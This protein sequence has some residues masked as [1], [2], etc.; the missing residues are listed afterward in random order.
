MPVF[1]ISLPDLSEQ[2]KTQTD[3]TLSDT[4]E[5]IRKTEQTQRE[6]DQLKRETAEIRARK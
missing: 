1:G 2:L 3:L 4:A 6:I 5:I